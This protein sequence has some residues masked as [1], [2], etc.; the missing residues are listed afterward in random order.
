MPLWL[1]LI[2][3]GRTWLVCLLCLDIEFLSSSLAPVNIEKFA[4][5]P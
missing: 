4:Y 2:I 3:S 5:V 1:K